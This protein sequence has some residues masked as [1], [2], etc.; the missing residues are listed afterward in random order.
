[1]SSNALEISIEISEKYNNSSRPYFCS[2]MY[3]NHVM[4][5]KVLPIEMLKN[6]T[7]HELNKKR[8]RT[9]KVI[10]KTMDMTG[11]NWKFVVK[12]DLLPRAGI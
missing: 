4:A 9:S 8:D 11:I 2:T 1:M 5:S 12:L 10:I 6:R 7:F 3:L